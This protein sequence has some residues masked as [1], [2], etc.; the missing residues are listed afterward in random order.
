MRI[1]NATIIL[2]SGH[3]IVIEDDD[4]VSFVD[5]IFEGLEFVAELTASPDRD[6]DGDFW[7]RARVVDDD[8]DFWHGAR[9]VFD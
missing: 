1:E 7:H 9:V 5:C 3:P 4:K 8:G 2:Q 6:D